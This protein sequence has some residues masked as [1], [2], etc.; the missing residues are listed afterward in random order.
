MTRLE[1]IRTRA[2]LRHTLIGRS[3]CAACGGGD[4]HTETCPNGQAL[5][6][7]DLV[8]AL[9]KAGLAFVKAEDEWR[10]QKGGMPEGS[11][12]D[13]LADAYAQMRAALARLEG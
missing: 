12:D 6:L 10:E 4:A 9:K 13:P 1:E 7:L 11:F 3:F 8:D 5:F 2:A